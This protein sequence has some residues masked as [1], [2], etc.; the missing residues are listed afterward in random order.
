MSFVGTRAG[1]LPLYMQ[2]GTTFY[3]P[4]VINYDFNLAG[5][6]ARMHIREHIE[7]DT[8]ILNLTTENG[9]ITLLDTTITLKLTNVETRTIPILKGVYDLELI[10]PAPDF[11]VSRFFEGVIIF[12]PE[13]TRQ[14]E[15]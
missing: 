5:W 13:V 7:D 3:L 10:S 9:R 6:T 2:L 11:F 12:S 14:H 8:I 4:I 15:L 1:D